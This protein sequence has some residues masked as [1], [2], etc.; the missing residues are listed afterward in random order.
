[1]CCLYYYYYFYY[2]YYYY[3]YYHYHYH[4]HYHHYHGTV[5]GSVPLIE[6]P[7]V[8]GLHLPMLETFPKPPLKTHQLLKVSSTE[9]K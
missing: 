8:F 1:M 9:H 7:L 4:Y 2:Y 3:Y 5:F 6:V